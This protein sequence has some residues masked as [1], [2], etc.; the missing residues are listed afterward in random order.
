MLNSYS[1]LALYATAFVTQILTLVGIA[2]A[3]NMQVWYYGIIIGVSSIN[4][5]Y[6]ILNGLAADKGAD[7]CRQ[8]NVSGACAID[9]T[10]DFVLFFGLSGFSAGTMYA[11]YPAWF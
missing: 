11:N 2:P 3:I 4:A 5:F 10:E 1:K 6:V 9:F 8:G 7:K